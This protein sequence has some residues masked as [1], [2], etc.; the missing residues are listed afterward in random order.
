MLDIKLDIKNFVLK[1]KEEILLRPG[2]ECLIPEKMNNY[3][4]KLSRKLT[5]KIK[6]TIRK[7]EDDTT[8]TNGTGTA[9][10]LKKNLVLGILKNKN[11]EQE[12]NDQGY[13]SEEKSKQQTNNDKIK[14]NRIEIDKQTKKKLLFDAENKKMQINQELTNVENDIAIEKLQPFIDIFATKPSK[15]KLANIKP[16]HLELSDKK[17]VRIRNY[18]LA[19]QERAE[20]VKQA[21]MLEE[22]GVLSRQPSRYES[23][24]FLKKKG[25]EEYRFPVDYRQVNS[26]IEKRG[27]KPQKID[28]IW[29]YLQNKKYFTKLDLNS[30]YFQIPL[31]EPSKEVTGIYIEGINYVLNSIPQGLSLSPFIFQGVMN[32]VLYEILREKCL[33]YMDDILVYGETFEET[34]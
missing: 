14:I 29:P 18:Q 16:Q 7:N 33:V 6:L 1:V 3:N 11:E 25:E 12:E 15:I 13:E 20:L 23:P 32:E 31:D 17:P 30:G 22:A 27:D 28:N 4:L 10:R 5:K 2:D 19:F 34:K 8:I 9:K 21:K 26:K 24:V